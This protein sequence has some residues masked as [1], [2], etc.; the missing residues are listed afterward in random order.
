MDGATITTVGNCS[1]DDTGDRWGDPYDLV[2]LH[3]DAG[4]LHTGLDGD[5]QSGARLEEG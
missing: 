2:D 3:Y 5:I 1:C 4:I